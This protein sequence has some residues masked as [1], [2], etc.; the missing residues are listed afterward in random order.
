MARIKV[1]ADMEKKLEGIDEDVDVGNVEVT[2]NTLAAAERERRRKGLNE[3]GMEAT[4]HY[5]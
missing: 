2:A 3:V 1:S 4:T 5:I